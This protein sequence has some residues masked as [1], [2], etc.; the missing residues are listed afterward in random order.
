LEEKV[1]ARVNIR[2]RVQGVFFRSETRQEAISLGLD[3]WVRNVPDGTVEVV[4]EGGQASVERA[5]EWCRT[6]PRGALVS[7]VKITWEEPRDEDGFRV[8]H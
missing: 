8:L 2:G 5:T 7:D 4:L 6:G 3:G 1:R